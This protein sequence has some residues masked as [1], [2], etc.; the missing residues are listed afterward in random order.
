MVGNLFSFIKVFEDW[1]RDNTAPASHYILDYVEL[2]MS[3]NVD[4]EEGYGLNS[5]PEANFYYSWDQCKYDEGENAWVWEVNY[6]PTLIVPIMSKIATAP[7][8]SK[9][10]ISRS[11]NWEI[12]VF[13]MPSISSIL[14]H[15]SN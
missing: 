10:D 6:F 12:L 7:G 2:D 11:S 1:D 5:A 13:H 14:Q 15:H 8:L 3:Q 4:N 9:F